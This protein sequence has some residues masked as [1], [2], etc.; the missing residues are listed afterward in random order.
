MI[1]GFWLILPWFILLTKWLRPRA[2]N[3]CR[4]VWKNLE[5]PWFRCFALFWHWK[6]QNSET[7]E[8]PESSKRVKTVPWSRSL[9][10]ITKVKV[11][12]AKT[13][14]SDQQSARLAYL[15]WKIEIG[16]DWYRSQI[17]RDLR[18]K[19]KMCTPVHGLSGFSAIKQT[20]SPCTGVHNFT[21]APQSPS[22]LASV[23]ISSNFDLPA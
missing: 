16:R 21:F 7:S 15:S 2:R 18:A 19:V 12:L 11:K 23:P 5:A 3:C 14:L 17:G 9:C 10:H 13:L 1:V 6:R 4:C 22:N 20:E 8:L